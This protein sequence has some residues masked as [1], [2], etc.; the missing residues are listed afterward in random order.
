[1][2][3]SVASAWSTPLVHPKTSIVLF[4]TA[5]K[6]ALIAIALASPGPGYDTSTTLLPSHGDL[7]SDAFVRWDAIFFTQI[8]RRGYLFEHE[9]AF[10][11]GYT[12]LL[13]LASYGEI[14]SR[15]FCQSNID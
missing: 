7:I 5:W 14:A 6:A 9:W 2:F 11:W 15:I 13:R 8:A 1:M 3:D 4:F 10:G 12:W